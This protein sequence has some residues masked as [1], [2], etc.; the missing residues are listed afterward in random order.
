MYLVS[1][2]AENLSEVSLKDAVVWLLVP[3]S[4]LQEKAKKKAVIPEQTSPPLQL[5]RIF[6]H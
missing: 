2:E 4:G 3:I 6:L 5:A 1:A